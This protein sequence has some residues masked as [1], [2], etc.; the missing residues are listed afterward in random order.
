MFLFDFITS[1][2]RARENASVTYCFISCLLGGNKEGFSISS[3]GRDS[4]IKKTYKDNVMGRN[5]SMT[6]LSYKYDAFGHQDTLLM[7][8]D[9]F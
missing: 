7:K 3:S 2:K 9:I 1:K 4:H 5:Y 8:V 6:P